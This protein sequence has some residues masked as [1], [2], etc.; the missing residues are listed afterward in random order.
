M[1]TRILLFFFS[2]CCVAVAGQAQ[3]SGEIVR[4]MLQQQGNPEF[5]ECD[6]HLLPSGREKYEDLF[7]A[8]KNARSYVHLEY[9]I[10]RTDSIGMALLELLGEKAREGVEIRILID[11]Y[12][13]YKSPYPIP[14]GQLDIIRSSGIKIALFDPLRFPWLPNMYHRD[15]RKIVVID[16]L[17]AYTGGMNVADYYLHG[18]ERTGQWRDMQVRLSGSVVDEYQRIFAKI[19]E[20]TTGERLD[21]ALYKASAEAA[22]AEEEVANDGADKAT[23]CVVNRE[24]GKLS[25]QMRQAFVAALDASQEEV[26]IVNPYPTGTRSVT[27]AMKRAMKRGVRLQLMVS[28]NM[29][30]RITPEVVAIQMKKLMKRGAEVYYYE[31]GFHHTKVM[32]VDREF[33]TIGTAN[34]D[35]RSLR[36][37]YEVNAFIFSPLTTNR[38]DAIFDNDLQQSKILT[39]RNFKERFSLRQRFVGRLFWPVKCVL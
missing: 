25:R 7:R 19:W 36:Y 22:Q 12:G 26:R 33:C 27:R 8:V 9:F 34:L 17:Y 32:T 23:V 38:L 20:Q 24:P 4:T 35:G 16:G 1:K 37:D 11:A 3:T 29:D 14:E 13:N 10:L 31:D 18:T 28:A 21:A 30:N 6:I 2:I 39:P 5:T 15:H